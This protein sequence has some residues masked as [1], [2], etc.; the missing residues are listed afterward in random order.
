M[1]SFVL[2]SLLMI[3]FFGC[4]DNQTQKPITEQE[5][6]HSARLF[7]YSEL[8]NLLTIDNSSLEKGMATLGYKRIQTTVTDFDQIY[9]DSTIYK[10]G[11]FEKIQG[12]GIGFYFLFKQPS[13]LVIKDSIRGEGMICHTF[14]ISNLGEFKK[15]ILNKSMMKQREEVRYNEHQKLYYIS[16]TFEYPYNSTW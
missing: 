1:K 8:E 7:S 2:A 5:P 15:G 16:E 9:F 14:P 10:T 11:D 13:I 4:K 12:A 3:A 6:P